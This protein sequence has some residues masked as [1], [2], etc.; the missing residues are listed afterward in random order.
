MTQQ[1]PIAVYSEI[2]D[3]Q[4]VLLKRPGKEVE[5]L[6]PDHMARLLFDDIPALPVAQK[7]HDAFAQVLRDH[8][9]EVYYLE[10]LSAAALD[11]SPC[12]RESFVDDILQ[13]SGH[14]VGGYE[15]FIRQYLLSLS[16]TEL[17]DTV[18]CG[19]RKSELEMPGSK[20]LQ[21]LMDRRYPF[22][23]DPLP[24]LY[25]TRD[26]AASIGEGMTINR[27]A[28]QARR[29]ESLFMSYI[30]QYHPDFAPAQ[31]PLW[32]DRKQHHSMEGGD[33]LILASDTIA[34]GVSQRTVAPAI[35]NLARNLFARQTHITSILA[36]EIPE[37]RAFMHLDTVFT[38]VNHQQFTIH[39][40]IQNKQ[41]GLNIYI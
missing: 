9:A 41:G 5:N 10:D 30:V 12:V 14:T 33:Q 3:L 38:M 39:P 7:E 22:Y 8:G 13:E 37:T 35:E 34:I 36:F 6:V 15:D 40:A 23:L 20:S 17:I 19:L 32:L 2:G 21:D 1:Q 31:V 25:F 24:N 4:A 18:M 11:S 28:S 29:R 27:M 26:P 16:N